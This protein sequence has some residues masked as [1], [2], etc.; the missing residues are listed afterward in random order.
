[1]S[2]QTKEAIPTEQAKPVS[3]TFT[4]WD[5]FAKAG[6]RPVTITCQAYKPVHLSD[7]SCHT[8]LQFSAAAFKRHIEADHG[9]AIQLTLKKVD[10]TSS[11]LWKELSESGLEA[12]DF[13]CDI[14]DRQLTFHPTSIL[15]CM[16][17][18]SGKT[19]RVFPGGHFNITLGLSPRDYEENAGETSEQDA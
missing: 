8:N 6:L 11:P 19:R 14:C 12:H 2:A 7:R 16:R 17:A 13:R 18:H 5:A 9:S 3:K 10:G 4:K 1:M 15:S